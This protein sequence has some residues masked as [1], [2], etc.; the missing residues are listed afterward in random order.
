MSVEKILGRLDQESDRSTAGNVSQD[1]ASGGVETWAKTSKISSKAENQGFADGED[2]RPSRATLLIALGM[3]NKLEILLEWLP[4]TAC[5]RKRKAGSHLDQFL[6]DIETVTHITGSA[7]NQAGNEDQ[8][9]AEVEITS[10]DVWSTDKPAEESVQADRRSHLGIQLKADIEAVV[11]KEKAHA[12][13]LSDD[14]IED[15]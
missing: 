15:D 13:V 9:D 5:I 10:D 12:L 7:T 3:S 1:A 14:D 11:P 4:F 8:H 2:N 6:K